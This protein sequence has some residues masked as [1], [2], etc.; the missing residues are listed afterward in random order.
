VTAGDTWAQLELEGGR[1]LSRVS[2]LPAGRWF[3]EGLRP[4]ELNVTNDAGKHW[5]TVVG[6][7][8]PNGIRWGMAFTSDVQGMMLVETPPDFSDSWTIMF[9]TQDGG[10]HWAPARIDPT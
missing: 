4:G 8:L 1:R 10:Q 6:Q 7:G 3:V 9:V 5:T 2:F